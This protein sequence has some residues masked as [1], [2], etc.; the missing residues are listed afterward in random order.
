[1]SLRQMLLV[2]GALTLAAATHAQAQTRAAPATPAL[3]V[4]LEADTTWHAAR[5]TRVGGCRAVALEKD[6]QADGGFLA[7]PFRKV[8][9]AQ[10]LEP[11]ITATWVDVPADSL[12]AWRRCEPAV[13][14]N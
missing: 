10:T 13:P 11:F 12:A 7:Y 6:V 14:S 2:S 1:M 5:F 8:T 9:R 3:R 4:Q